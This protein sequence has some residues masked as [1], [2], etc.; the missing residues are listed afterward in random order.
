MCRILALGTV[1]LIF[2]SNTLSAQNVG[3]SVN[4]HVQYG[5]GTETGM[6]GEQDKEYF[7]SF[8]DLRLRSDGITIGVRL[9]LRKP[10]E[11]GPDEQAITKRYIEYRREGLRVRAGDLYSLFNRG[12]SLNLFENRVIRYDTGLDGF[13][14]EYDTGLFRAT[15]LGGQI[16]YLEQLTFEDPTIHEETHSIRAAQFHLRPSDWFNMN[17]SFVRAESFIP[18]YPFSP[19]FSDTT[20]SKHHIPEASMTL[21]LPAANITLGYAHKFSEEADSIKTDGGGLYASVSHTGR[22]YGITLEYKD[23]RYDIRDPLDDFNFLRTSR[24]MPFQNPPIGH[25]EHSYTL[26]SREPYLVN[27]ND[28]TGFFLDAFFAATPMLMINT[29]FAMASRHYAY[30]LDMGT[31]TFERVRKGSTWLPSSNKK[32]NPFY[33]FYFEADYLLKDFISYLKFVYNYRDMHEYDNFLPE[34]SQT[35]RYHNVLAELNYSF[36]PLWSMKATI[37]RQYEY[38]SI[39]SPEAN[40]FSQLHTIQFSRSPVFSIAGRFEFT[41]SKND[42]S[43]DKSWYFIDTSYRIGSSHIITAGYGSERGGVVC[44]NGVCRVV[45]AFEGFRFSLTSTF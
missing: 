14:A 26:M 24:M 21:R 37:E 3:F 32:R 18:D 19:G 39:Y 9:E 7:E 2:N 31:F 44:T 43:G 35:E 29:S 25:K 11:F 42:P 30:E 5:I 36:S 17:A 1:F 45:N 41:N 38:R 40:T 15:V 8:T 34:F 23:Y 20:V 28:E 33:E 4:N 12:L 16:R 27:F 10:A 22:R 13:L 6:F